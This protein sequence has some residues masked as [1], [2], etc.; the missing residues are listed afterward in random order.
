MLPADARS[1]SVS[2]PR[3]AAFSCDSSPN[4]KRAPESSA[5][6]L[7]PRGARSAE[8]AR[9]LSN[10]WCGRTSGLSDAELESTDETDASESYARP[11][12]KAWRVGGGDV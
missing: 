3:S 10:F 11:V 12:M 2:C 4:S 6:C 5:R 1:H 8:A 9:R 7:E